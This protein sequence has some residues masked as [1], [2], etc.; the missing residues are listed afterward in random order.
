MRF[1][2][3]VPKLQSASD[4]NKKFEIKKDAAGEYCV[5]T[6]NRK[7][8]YQLTLAQ[9]LSRFKGKCKE[10]NHTGMNFSS[11]D[12]PEKEY[13]SFR[14]MIAESCYLVRYPEG[15]EW[16]FIIPCTKAENEK[17][18]T[19]TTVNR[20]PKFEFVYSDYNK[21]PVMQFDIETTLTRAEVFNL[22]PDPY[23]VSFDGLE[24]KFRTVFIN[25][26]YKDIFLRFDIGF[27]HSRPG[28]FYAW[29]IKEGG[30]IV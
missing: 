24:D 18:I 15:E 11:V 19:N 23:G 2:F 26:D 6:A 20:N 22:L 3:N 17:G 12:I 8:Y 13:L 25:T 21:V 5:V 1:G 29:M 7:K 4:S 14:E 9:L 16:P 10:V 28:D 30:R 27:A